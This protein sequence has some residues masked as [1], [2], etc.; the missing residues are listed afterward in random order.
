LPGAHIA[1]DASR[2]VFTLAE[3]RAG[4][5]VAY[6]IVIDAAIP[7]VVPRA[8]DAGGCGAPD[9]SGLI[10]FESFEGNGQHY[11][12]CDEGLCRP[13]TGTA[14]TISAGHYGHGFTWDGTN[15][16]GP[17]DTGNPKGAAFPA[18]TYALRVSAVG[19]WSA[20]GAMVPFT[21]VGTLPIT[22]VP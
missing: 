22:L 20:D 9:A 13:P 19:T 1:I 4:I 6:E 3:A 21:V 5:T 8:Q 14:V 7:N 10:P 15:W 17:S 12:I 11:C 18:G 2:C 16:T